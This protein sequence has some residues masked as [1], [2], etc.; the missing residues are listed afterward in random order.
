M[1]N[2]APAVRFA[3]GSRRLGAARPA[4]LPPCLAYRRLAGHRDT[5]STGKI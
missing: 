4:H 3:K 5:Y 2:L 1:D